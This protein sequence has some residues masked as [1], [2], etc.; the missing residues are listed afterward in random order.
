MNVL[1]WLRLVCILALVLL[2]IA[3]VLTP[4]AI[5]LAQPRLVP[6]GAA[7]AD[8]DAFLRHAV[9]DPDW[10]PD[11]EFVEE[12]LKVRRKLLDEKEKE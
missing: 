10:K 12:W 8:F 6:K 4:D 2:A 5:V 3:L 1:L 11:P 7:E 9:A